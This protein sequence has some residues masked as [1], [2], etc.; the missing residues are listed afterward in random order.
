M[1]TRH[2]TLSTTHYVGPALSL[3]HYNDA[4]RPPSGGLLV[5]YI[6]L[7]DQLSIQRGYKGFDE[8]PPFKIQNVN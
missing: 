5:L 4:E 7:Q 2:L 6:M 8:P 1:S 3:P